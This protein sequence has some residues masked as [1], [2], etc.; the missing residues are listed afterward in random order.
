M[1]IQDFTSQRA[2]ELKANQRGY[3]AFVP[4]KPPPKIELSWN[5]IRQVSRAE[6]ALAELN[7][8]ATTLPNADMLALPSLYK[9]AVLSSKIEGTQTEI[10]DLYIY[11]AD[12]TVQSPDVNEVEN[13]KKAL[14]QGIKR[15]KS[16]PICSRLILE[17][18]ATLM[19]G[20]RGQQFQSGE[21]RTTQNWIGA[22]GCTLQDATFVPVPPEELHNKISELE[23][24]LNQES[25]EE[26]TLIQCA[27]AHYQFEV[28]HPFADGN[29]RIGRLLILL[30]LIAKGNLAQPF[31]YLSGFFEEHRDEYYRL[32]LQTSQKGMWEEWIE[33]FLNG[34]AVQS[35]NALAQ[36]RNLIELQKNYRNKLLSIKRVPEAAQRIVEHI[37]S[38][39]IIHPATLA[40]E[41]G[42][43]FQT[44]MLGI[45]R[46]QELGILK[47]TTGK[48][49]NRYFN[50]HELLKLIEGGE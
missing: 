16:L 40:Q 31:L 26:P 13:Y 34:I 21:Y 4:H 15:L 30:I 3:T 35:E 18:H 46:L 44:F 37:F 2:G 32:L 42:M 8:L 12:K 49:R 6:K 45:T 17:L 28:V 20:V 50:A 9:E 5:L 11:N 22:A 38:N 36:V 25:C 33:Y 47:E 48:K 10:E 39:P 29:G 41:W 24:Y 14:E 27:I 43:S 7:G 1:K 23:N 19:R